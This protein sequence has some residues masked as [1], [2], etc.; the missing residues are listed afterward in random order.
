MSIIPLAFR[1]ADG[2][3]RSIFRRSP[4]QIAKALHNQQAAPRT[5]QKKKSRRAKFGWLERLP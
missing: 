1:R 2:V 3:G 5:P 4:R